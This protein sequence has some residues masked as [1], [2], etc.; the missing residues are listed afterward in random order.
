VGHDF[1]P[2]ESAQIPDRG[3]GAG[4]DALPLSGHSQQAQEMMSGGR[5]KGQ[6]MIIGGRG[7]AWA[8]ANLRA[9][10]ADGSVPS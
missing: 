7:D 6:A 4:C 3:D 10:G 8:A 1:G 2:T 5:L 9:G